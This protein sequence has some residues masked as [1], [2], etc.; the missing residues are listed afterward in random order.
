MSLAWILI[1]V[2][3]DTTPL[4]P[5]ALIGGNCDYLDAET[6][7]TVFDVRPTGSEFFDASQKD[8]WEFNEPGIWRE[9]SKS[10]V[11]TSSNINE[12]SVVISARQFESG[13]KFDD[14]TSLPPFIIKVDEFGAIDRRF[15]CFSPADKAAI[16][17]TSNYGEGGI[18]MTW[19][20]FSIHVHVIAG[21]EFENE[22]LKVRLDTELEAEWVLAQHILKR[23]EAFKESNRSS[24][25]ASREIDDCI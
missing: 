22:I 19:N 20:Q 13:E 25:V 23:L 4:N 15:S 14:G 21:R 18:A 11:W 16:L 2:E 9:A 17:K 10:C 12:L 8:H 7:N 6:L 5:F 1:V 3:D 24:I